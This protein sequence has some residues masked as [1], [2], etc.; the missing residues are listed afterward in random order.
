MSE[1]L[2]EEESVIIANNNKK[3]T[4]LGLQLGTFYEEVRVQ[5]NNLGFVWNCS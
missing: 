1:F 3:K 5:I 2:N 4:F